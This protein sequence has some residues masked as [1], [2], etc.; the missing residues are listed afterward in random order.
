MKA[1]LENSNRLRA[2][3][4]KKMDPALYA[5][6]YAPEGRMLLAGGY[7]MHGRDMIHKKMASFMHLVGPMD[8]SIC[9]NNCWEIE[10]VIFEQGQYEFISID[11]GKLFNRGQY[12]IQWMKQD[13]GTY[14]II[15]DF[16]IDSM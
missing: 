4:F 16:E 2:D 6:V 15:N 13:D 3:A 8:V 10:N 9:I 11:N 5:S 1:I 14:K 12:L 7:V